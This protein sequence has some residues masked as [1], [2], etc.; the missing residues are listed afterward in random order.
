M[1][2]RK[3]ITERR[4]IQIGLG[5]DDLIRMLQQSKDDRIFV[6]HLKDLPENAA[7]L[8]VRYDHDYDCFVLKVAHP[9]FDPVQDG[10]RIPFRHL[11]IY[12][13]EVMKMVPEATTND[14]DS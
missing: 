6:P 5:N 12:L 4:F 13:Y 1:D 11:D 3:A 14:R 2:M 8:A 9:T 10:Q 7:I